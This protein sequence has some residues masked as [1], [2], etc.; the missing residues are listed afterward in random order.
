VYPPA[1][2]FF[3]LAHHDVTGKP[4]LHAAATGLGLAA[5]LLGE[6]MID[7][8]IELHDGTLRVIDASPPRDALAHATLDQ[9]I[10]QPQHQGVRVWLDFLRRGA[11]DSVAQRM[12]RGGHVRQETSRRLLRRVVTWVPTDVNTAAWPWAR[13]SNAL[14]RQE[15]VDETDVFLLGL[16]AATGLEA[17]L[18]DS[19]PSS[20]ES[21]LR[22]LLASMPA[23][24]QE[25]L[26]YTRAAV[27]DA[28]LSYRG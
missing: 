13:L 24:F 12:W 6:L 9:L 25:L 7:G 3:R 27:G 18:L 11:Y 22:R 20:A 26:A 28:V 16:A 23:Q 2:D 17:D 8:G 4:R 19:G 14:Y 15:P 1:D 10:A 21:Y 5:A